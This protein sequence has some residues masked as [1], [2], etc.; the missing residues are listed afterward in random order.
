MGKGKCEP[1]VGPYL[2]TYA[3]AFQVSGYTTADGAGLLT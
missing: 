3:G 1:F 2:D